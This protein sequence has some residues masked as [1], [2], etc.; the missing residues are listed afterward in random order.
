MQDTWG[1]L[2]FWVRLWALCGLLFWWL[3]GRLVKIT[4]LNHVHR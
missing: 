2:S 4:V 1:V 3:M